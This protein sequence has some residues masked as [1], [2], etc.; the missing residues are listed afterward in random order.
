MSAAEISHKLDLIARLTADELRGWWSLG[1][2]MRPAFDGERAA[3]TA[4]AKA[5]GVVL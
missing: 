3:L 5:L 1:L 4:R 2:S